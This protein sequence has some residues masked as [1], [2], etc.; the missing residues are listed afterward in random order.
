MKETRTVK[1][2]SLPLSNNRITEEVNKCRLVYEI[3][4]FTTSKKF[5]NYKR[6]QGYIIR[7]IPTSEVNF[8]TW[9]GC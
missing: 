8:Y 6:K 7:A 9:Q 2:L 5:A 4:D 1:N 3:V